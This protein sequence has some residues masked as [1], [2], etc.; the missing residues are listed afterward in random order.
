MNNR[1]RELRID[2]GLNQNELSAKAKISARQL[3][4][5]ECGKSNAKADTLLSIATALE[6]T[7]GYLL[8]ESNEKDRLR[9]SQH[10]RRSPQ[11]GLIKIL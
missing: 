9:S 5:I 10:R 2:R 11:K 8:K 6:T 7:V 4:L 3:S 1:I